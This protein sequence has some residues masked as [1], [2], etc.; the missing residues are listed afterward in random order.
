VQQT[1]TAG[2]TI[3][4]N[5]AKDNMASLAYAAACAGKAYAHSINNGALLNAMN[6]SKTDILSGPDNL[7]D[8]KA[9]NIYNAL[10]PLVANLSSFGAT[11][12]SLAALQT[13]ITAF[14]IF[15]GQTQQQSSVGIAATNTLAGHFTDQNDSLNNYLDPLMVQYAISNPTFYNQYNENRA[16][17]NMGHRKTL[18]ITGFI[19]NNQ[20]PAQ[21]LPHVLITLTGTD[22]LGNTVNKSKHTDASGHYRFTRLHIG[23]YTI[24]PSLSGFT[25]TPKTSSVTETQVINNDFVMVSLPMGG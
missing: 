11:T 25:T 9:S 5:Q 2:A 18:V 3:T 6:I 16:I 19:S 20:T 1:G 7:A 21:T 13:S 23:S 4:K 15:L 10:L 22:S 24:T 12:A 14:S 8:D 17:Q